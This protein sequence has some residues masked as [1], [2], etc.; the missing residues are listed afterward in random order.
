[1]ALLRRRR[2]NGIVVEDEE[3]MCKSREHDKKINAISGN[4]EN[5]LLLVARVR[6]DQDI[7]PIPDATNMA[8]LNR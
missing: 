7:L 4:K 8:P 5:V 3:A 2:T 6:P 1:M